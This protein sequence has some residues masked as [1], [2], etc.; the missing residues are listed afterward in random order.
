MIWFFLS[1]FGYR[2]IYGGANEHLTTAP[3]EYYR[4]VLAGD[5]VGASVSFWDNATTQTLTVSGIPAGATVAR[6]LLFWGCECNSTSD[7]TDI[8]FNGTPI[9]GSVIASTSTL[10]W[11]TS[12]YMV[13]AANVTSLVSGNGSYT[14]TVPRALSS[15]PG[16]DGA[17]LYVVYCDVTQPN[18]TVSIYAMA[19]FVNSSTSS[20]TQ[21]G[22]TATSSPSAKASLTVG[23]PQD[24]LYN[25]G[26]FNGGAGSV[27]MDFDGSFPG[28]HYG[29][30][31]ADVSSLMS[32]S[33]SSVSWSLTS[34]GA[35]CISPNVSV[36]SITSVD[37][38]TSS[39][40]SG[41]DD[42]VIVVEGNVVIGRGEFSIYDA[43]GRLVWKGRG[44]YHLPPG[45][46][47]AVA[48]GKTKRIL[49]R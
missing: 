7:L 3:F 16:A 44:E 4:E 18:R 49:V 32:P 33:A 35:D 25:Y 10:C 19:D 36:L 6:A 24:G 37:S 34:T 45:L 14:I 47:F 5:F 9:T 11:G 43:S 31:E 29:Y 27:N 1:G 46:F 28:N 42:P 20:W 38:P 8:T 15:T 22:F 30:W 23:D 21:T 41:Y 39:C 26:T 17:T 2:E 12:S 48:G 13:Y 40:V